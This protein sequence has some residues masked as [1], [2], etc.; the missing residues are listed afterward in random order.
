[1]DIYSFLKKFDQVRIRIFVWFRWRNFPEC[2]SRCHKWWC[3]CFLY[4]DFYIHK[5]SKWF[6]RYVLNSS[7]SMMIRVTSS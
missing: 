4:Y 5:N 1:L 3:C 6:C 2:D 7:Q